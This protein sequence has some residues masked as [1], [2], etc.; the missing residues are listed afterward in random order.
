MSEIFYCP[1]TGL[2]VYSEPWWLNKKAGTD[3]TA[4]FSTIDNSI[5]YSSPSGRAD[6][7]AVEN[8]LLLNDSVAEF[9]TSD[10]NQYVQIEDYAALK[11]STPDYS[12]MF[13]RTMNEKENLAG[14]IFCNTPPS[15]DLPVHSGERL[16]NNGIKFF[17]ADDYKDA[18]TLALKICSH[19]NIPVSTPDNGKVFRGLCPSRSLEPVKLVPKPEMRIDTGD[20]V[21]EFS[22]INDNIVYSIPH[23][24][25]ERKHLAALNTRWHRLI[26]EVSNTPKIEYILINGAELKGFHPKALRPY[27]DLLR[28]WHKYD[29]VKMHII[30]TAD[31]KIINTSHVADVFMPFEIRTAPDLKSACKLIRQNSQETKIKPDAS[32][33][34]AGNV[35]TFIN[36]INWNKT[37]LDL[38]V[39][40]SHPQFLTMK[41]IK[42]LKEEIDSLLYDNK[43]K[44]AEL[45]LAN[46]KQ[47]YLLYELQHRVKNSFQL[48]NGYIGLKKKTC[49]S[50]ETAGV[51][52]EMYF[53]IQAVSELYSMLSPVGSA[54][55]S[56]N[57]YLKELLSKFQISENKFQII[58]NFDEVSINA[59]TIIPVGIIV[60]ELVTNSM[61]H[62]FPDKSDG[63]I[64]VNLKN[65]G[66]GFVLEYSDN[67]TGFSNKTGSSASLGLNLINNLVRQINAVIDYRD[68]E[69]F[70]CKIRKTV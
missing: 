16:D 52:D 11:S 65:S 48:I 17:L 6:Q 36:R 69:G 49:I 43:C 42:L 58:T 23:G 9:V 44:E 25:L 14:L 27:G 40:Q 19:N 32:K 63:E 2:K 39:D 41:A 68:A 37:G 29:P 54:E 5:I 20:F 22:I 13:I 46:E 33:D 47:E 57:R 10:K 28:E 66:H 53:K 64:T 18:V 8:S 70:F 60:S 67:G 24:T 31:Q 4:N 50:D 61:K 3:F 7:A 12:N 62:A 35:V 21:N 56:L 15:L 1:V 26:S 38:P 34:D 30:I 45:R 55:T 51:L 59:D